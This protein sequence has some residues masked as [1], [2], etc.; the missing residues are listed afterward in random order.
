MNG[1]EDKREEELLISLK[2]GNNTALSVLYNSYVDQLYFFIL[3]TAKSPALA[4]DVIQD[5][6][7]KI[8]DARAFIDPAKPFKPYL[9]TIARRHL[10]NLLKRASHEVEI[11]EEI[12]KYS[13]FSENA[14]DL[15]L[16]YSESNDLLKSAINQLAPRSR[17]VFLRCKMEGFTYR[18]VASQLGITEGTVNSQVVKATKS[19]K[20]YFSLHYI[21]ALFPSF[22]S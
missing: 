2:S 14:T 12:K 20:R 13:P 6:F 18:Q 22:F 10:I 17:E 1:H 9:Y 7:I 19:I 4:E 3:K 15:Q 16:D 11:I 5:V 8:W 21:I